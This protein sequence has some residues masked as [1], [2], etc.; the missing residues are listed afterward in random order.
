M[1]ILNG[2]MYSMWF[3]ELLLGACSFWAFLD[4]YGT[5]AVF[6]ST[7]KTAYVLPSLSKPTDLNH[8]DLSLEK[9]EFFQ[10]GFG[11][12][13]NSVVNPMYPSDLDLHFHHSSLASSGL[14]FPQP[15]TA[16]CLCPHSESMTR[17][18][19][20]A[21]VVL[22]FSSM[23]DLPWYSWI[24]MTSLHVFLSFGT[25]VPLVLSVGTLVTL[26]VYDYSLYSFVT[27]RHRL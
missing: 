12:H 2:F 5:Q 4:P 25:L 6:V 23:K 13:S 15:P 16:H 1:M 7:Y 20:T 24:P 27:W 22:S 9:D 10:F 14:V 8:P 3:T 11:I 19:M 21:Q 26:L 17:H 18:I